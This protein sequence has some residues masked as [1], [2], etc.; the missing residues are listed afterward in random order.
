MANPSRQGLGRR[1][2]TSAS[3]LS[4][5]CRRRTQP[6]LPRLYNNLGFLL[7]RFDLDDHLP[8]LSDGVL[9][10]RHVLLPTWLDMASPTVVRW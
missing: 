4:A 10:L 3:A 8:S 9:L 5:A 2:G 1:R 7:H 6:P